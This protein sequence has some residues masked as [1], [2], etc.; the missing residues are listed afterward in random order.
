LAGIDDQGK[1]FRQDSLLEETE[2]LLIQGCQKLVLEGQ[3]A[4]RGQLNLV[5]ENES[6]IKREVSESIHSR[7]LDLWVAYFQE[8][9]GKEWGQKRITV[10][11][12]GRSQNERPPNVDVKYSPLFGYTKTRIRQVVKDNFE[13]VLAAI[14]EQKRQE[15][16]RKREEARRR[17]E[18][19][20]QEEMRRQTE[21][22]RQEEARKQ[23]EENRQRSAAR[24]K[25]EAERQEE[26]RQI[27]E[28]SKAEVLKQEEARK[29]AEARMREEEAR[30]RARSASTTDGAANTPSGGPGAIGGGSGKGSGGGNGP[31][32]GNGP[33]RGN[34]PGSGKGP[35]SGGGPGGGSGV[36]ATGGGPAAGGS[37]VTPLAAG[38]PS[39]RCNSW[40]Y[41]LLGIIIGMLL[42]MAGRKRAGSSHDRVSR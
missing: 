39:A 17:E 4:A 38:R 6:A 29:Q 15:E 11:W 20:R 5:Q 36:L 13:M 41:I 21:V 37:G 34:G 19:S 14:E 42:A 26:E 40:I 18:A 30:Q 12:R 7:T 28:R 31:G 3:E 9:I 33:D 35:G 1:P 8:T 16:A 25:A 2:N 10:V 32:A 23:E 24:M 22:R 27:A